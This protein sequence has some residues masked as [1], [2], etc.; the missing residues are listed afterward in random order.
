VKQQ[1]LLQLFRVLVQQLTLVGFFAQLV[2]VVVPVVF[3]KKHSLQWVQSE[4]TP[5]IPL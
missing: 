3:K 5:K 1:Q 4:Q 2:R